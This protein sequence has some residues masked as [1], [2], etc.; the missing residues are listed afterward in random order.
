M[1]EFRS[2]KDPE[3]Y[4]KVKEGVTVRQ[5]AEDG[6]ELSEAIADPYGD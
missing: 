5:V 1:R 4:Q 6:T 2:C 3:L